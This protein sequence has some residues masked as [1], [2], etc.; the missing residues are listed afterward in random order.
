MIGKHIQYKETP[1][2][3]FER[4]I[5]KEVS[6]QEVQFQQTGAEKPYLVLGVVQLV[7]FIDSD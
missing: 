3:Y 4:I 6:A 1:G 5:G 7:I 2:R